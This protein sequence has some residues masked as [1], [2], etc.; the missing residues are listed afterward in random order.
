MYSP[1]TIL[2]VDDDATTNFLNQRLLEQMPEKPEVLVAGNGQ[3][4][5]ALLKTRCEAPATAA[6]PTLVLLDLHMPVLNGFEF[7]HALAQRPHA[8]PHPFVVVLLTTSQ[9]DQDL[10]Q[11][12]HL[13]VTACLTK[14]LTTAAVQQLLN[15]YFDRSQPVMGK[16]L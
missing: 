15:N 13:P 14:P 3:D 6:C 7:L 8:L 11:A 4:A 1:L 12:Q 2:L 10:V 9:L 5:L 16:T